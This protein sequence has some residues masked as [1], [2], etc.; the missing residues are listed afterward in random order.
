[1]LEDV[2]EFEFRQV[3]DAADVGL[4]LLDDG[5]RILAWNDC[6]A[7]LTRLRPETVIGKGLYEVFPDL[8]RTRLPAAIDEALRITGGN[9]SKAAR[10][11]G[12]TRAQLRHR[13]ATLKDR[14]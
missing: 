3:F 4:I 12:L 10:E 7:R 11:L 14:T 2:T 5:A 1:M 6:I 9:V 8:Q 13:V